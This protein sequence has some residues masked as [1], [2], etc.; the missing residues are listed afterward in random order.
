MRDEVRIEMR[1][2]PA[3]HFAELS[4]Q[5]QKQSAATPAKGNEPPLL[6]L[7]YACLSCEALIAESLDA[8]SSSISVDDLFAARVSVIERWRTGTKRLSTGSSVSRGAVAAVRN[9]CRDT[10]NY[11][12]LVRSRN[13]L[14]HPR[15]HTEVLD[16]RGHAIQDG[17]VERL[18]DDLRRSV[19]TLP[20]TRPTFPSIV[21]NPAS[22]LWAV[23]T[24]AMM[25]R[26]LYSVVEKALPDHWQ[27]TIKGI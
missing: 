27:R 25:V 24:M 3:W 12:L 17:R 1:Y 20:V 14:V 22:A 23:A 19:P 4:R 10:G 16:S 5:W 15:V 26:H 11:G 9:E 18:V 2:M 6:A 21:Q 7:I 8:Q 13:K